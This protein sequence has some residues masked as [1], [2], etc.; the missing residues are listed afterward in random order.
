MTIKQPDSTN[1]ST[2]HKKDDSSSFDPQLPEGEGFGTL[3]M[4]SSM[5]VAVAKVIRYMFVFIVQIVLM[6]L[7]DPS[8]FGLM[9]YVMVVMGF[10][11][12]I[13]T[14][15]LSISIVQKKEL[16]QTELGPVFSLNIVLCILL[17]G[18]AWIV[19]PRF[20]HY[21]GNTQ[22]TGLIRL[23]SIAIPLGG[24]VVIHRALLQRRFKYNMLSFAEVTSAIIS[25]TVSLVMAVMGYGILSLVWGTVLFQLVSTVQLLLFQKGVIPRF[26]NMKLALPLFSFGLGWVAQQLINYIT[27]NIDNLIV[28]KIFGE[29]ALG[30]YAIAYD[31]IRTPQLAL[32]V[33]MG[34]VVMSVLSRLQGDDTRFANAYL[35]LTLI[36]ASAATPFLMLIGTMSEDLMHALTIF[37]PSDKWLPI[38]NPLHILAFMGVLYSYSSFSVTAWVA[39]GRIDIQIYWAL[40]MLGTVVVSVLAGSPFGIIGVCFAML[41]RAVIVFP[42]LLWVCKKT[43]GFSPLGYLKVLMPSAVCGAGFV[44]SVLG[45]LFMFPVTSPLLHTVRLF[46]GAAVGFLVYTALFYLLFRKQWRTIVSFFRKRKDA[47]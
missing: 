30:I 5:A 27:F 6:N 7:L 45:V 15:G 41:I 16:Q 26:K 4:R 37:R 14:A 43:L 44:G 2:I 38:V 33:I 3:A 12:L 21:F 31:F 11:N 39:K 35:K 22:L 17:Y 47:A 23:G 36:V 40:A 25:S 8:E 9:R 24:V 42:I 28:G 20:A 10:I 32:G 1:Q 46:G 29:E 34:T 13:G 18:L 19:A